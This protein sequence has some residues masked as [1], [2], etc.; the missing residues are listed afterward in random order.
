[1]LT[2][3]GSF[4]WPQLLSHS[5][6]SLGPELSTVSVFFPASLSQVSS[7]QIVPIQESWFPNVAYNFLFYKRPILKL[8]P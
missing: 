2:K 5:L 1:M 3:T 6:S 7:S 4:H 8:S